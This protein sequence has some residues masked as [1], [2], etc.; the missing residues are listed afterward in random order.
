MKKFIVEIILLTFWQVVIIFGKLLVFGFILSK[1]QKWTQ[2]NYQ[3]SI[4]WKGI[5][6]TAWLGTP[7]H[8]LSHALAAKIFLHKITGIKLFSPDRLS[9]ELGEVSHQ[10]NEKNIFQNIGNF[11]IGLA[12][13]IFGS[14]ILTMLVYFFLPNGKEIFAL[15]LSSEYSLLAFLKSSPAILIKLFTFENIKSLEF[16]IFLYISFCIASH[17]SP[18]KQDKKGMLNG[19]LFIIFILLLLNFF[20]LIFEIN[21]TEYIKK[22]MGYFKIFTTIF[23]YAIIISFSH[24]VISKIIFWIFKK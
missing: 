21:T 4:G 8:E 11:F 2:K 9:G 23:S 13:M 24:F 15:L 1:L 16:W 22:L 12:P 20:A 5:L 17:M 18:S 14:L 7:I 3:K 6:W 19:L 10:W